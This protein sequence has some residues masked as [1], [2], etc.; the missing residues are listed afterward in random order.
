M[1][2][3]ARKVVGDRMSW[4]LQELQDTLATMPEGCAIFG[5][6][7]TKSG[8]LSSLMSMNLDSYVDTYIK[9][10]KR[11]MDIISRFFIRGVSL[12]KSISS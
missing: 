3:G 10:I 1:A 8:M 9:G 11:I 6:T 7:D 5:E 12:S 4:T 2:I